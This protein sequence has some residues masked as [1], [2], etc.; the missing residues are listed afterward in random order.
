LELSAREVLEFCSD[1]V[2]SE[3]DEPCVIPE[4][5]FKEDEPAE[6]KQKKTLK[7]QLSP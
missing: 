1:C 4:A 2:L 5:F 3:D 7:K 6:S